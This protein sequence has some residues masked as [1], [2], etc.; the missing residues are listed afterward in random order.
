MNALTNAALGAASLQARPQA[1]QTPQFGA[2]VAARPAAGSPGASGGIGVNSGWG[3]PSWSS[4]SPQW[5]Q[6][7]AGAGNPGGATTTTSYEWPL[8]SRKT[9][10]KIDKALYK[11]L[12]GELKDLRKL[13]KHF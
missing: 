10:K 2:S 1:A 5:S 8:L 9:A 6:Y 4:A 3:A 13:V 12:R 11:Q 7:Y